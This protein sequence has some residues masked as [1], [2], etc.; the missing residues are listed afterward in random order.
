MRESLRYRPYG[1]AAILIEWP[2]KIDPEIIQ[3]ITRFERC[4]VK[5]EHVLDKIIAYHSLTVIYDS[6][7]LGSHGFQDQVLFSKVV[8]SLKE[9]YSKKTEE[10]F[11]AQKVW[12]IP[13]CYDLEF[14]WDLNEISK[15]KNLSVEELIE[16]HTQ[17]PY[18]IYFIGFQPGF[19]YLGGLN[20]RIHMPR[21]ANPRLRVEKG[22]VAIGG[23]QTGIYPSESAGGWNIIGKSPINFFDLSKS[24]PCF[25]KAGDLIQFQQV[26]KTLYQKFSEEVQNGQYQLQYKMQ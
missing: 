24:T 5:E 4:I 11:V 19:L 18:L 9:Q 22:A 16:L 7:F 25:A 20:K 6:S 3:D 12:Q 2:A 14:G 1:T 23:E 17:N 13:V 21:K 15:Q 10:P 26:N 8:Q